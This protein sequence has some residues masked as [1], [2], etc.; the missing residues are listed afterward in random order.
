MMM[1]INYPV[2][3]ISRLDS[4]IQRV[5]RETKLS[6]ETPKIHS[7]TRETVRNTTIK[8]AL[9]SDTARITQYC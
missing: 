1:T 5:V 2:L 3:S 4:P 8:I 9:E 7:L 6:P